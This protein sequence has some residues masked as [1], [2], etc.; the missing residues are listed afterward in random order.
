MTDIIAR[1]ADSLVEYFICNKSNRAVCI[2]MHNCYL[3][4]VVTRYYKESVITCNTYMT[5]THSVD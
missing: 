3:A 1:T 2:D 4:I 5:S